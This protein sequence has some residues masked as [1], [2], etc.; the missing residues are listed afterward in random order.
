MAESAGGPWDVVT[1]LLRAAGDPVVRAAGALTR[2]GTYTSQLREVAATAASAGL[3][4]LGLGP[5]PVVGDA[6]QGSTRARNGASGGPQARSGGDGRPVLLVHGYGANRS[7]WHFVERRLRAAGFDTIHAVNYH[8][9]TA[10]LPH[11]AGWLAGEVADLRERVGADGVHVVGHSLGGLVARYA[12][13]VLAAEGVA[14]CVTV[15]SPHGGVALVR[16][17][18]PLPGRLG[19]IARQ[20]R[21]DSAEMVLLRSSARPLDTRF[22][23]YAAGSDLLVPVGRALVRE[24]QLEATNLVIAHHGHLSLLF[25]SSLANSLVHQLRLGWRQPPARNRLPAAA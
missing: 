25:S 24:P 2:P 9:F 8:P 6:R 21:P 22:V 20:L 1:G 12:V 7:N 14:T 4:P 3:W 17:L 16:G 13:Q 15:A 18:R 11:L 23:A 19:T 5:P 10:D